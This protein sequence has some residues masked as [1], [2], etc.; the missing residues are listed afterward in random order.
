MRRVLL[1]LIL[2][3]LGLLSAAAGQTIVRTALA[4]RSGLL[5]VASEKIADP[6]F[7]QTVI[8]ITRHDRQGTSGLI[9]NRPL[10]TLPAE[11][12]AALPGNPHALFWGGPVSPLQVTGLLFGDQGDHGSPLAKGLHLL[13]AD[14][15][16]DML[17]TPSQG[18][19]EMRLYLGYAGWAPKQL[20]REIERGDWSVQA[21]D[22]STL[23][24]TPAEQ[25]W[26]QRVP[27]RPSPWI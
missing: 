8:L 14:Q 1:I 13:H 10:G 20:A 18:A 4:P 26:P 15:L 17:H 23:Q 21:V 22:P 2:L 6:R 27:P 11:V 9:L 12:E 25:L 3:Q 19:G 7:Q 24:H 5:L 16:A